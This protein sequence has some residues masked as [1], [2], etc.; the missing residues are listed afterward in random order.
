MPTRK[1]TKRG[2]KK[3]AKKSGP[4]IALYAVPIHQCISRG[5]L[6]EM[7]K[8][9]AQARKHISDVTSALA[10]LDKAIGLKKK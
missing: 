1:T 3:T 10:M 9:A 6:A 7:R 2:A 5:N 8:M 4:I